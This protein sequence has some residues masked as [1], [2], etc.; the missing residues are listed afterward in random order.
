M[1]TYNTTGK[2]VNTDQIS[3]ML[4]FYRK[5]CAN[6]IRKTCKERYGTFIKRDTTVWKWRKRVVEN[7]AE[8]F[9]RLG[10]VLE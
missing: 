4:P 1:A 6:P 3:Q 10:I 2:T 5:D 7:L 8:V 9:D